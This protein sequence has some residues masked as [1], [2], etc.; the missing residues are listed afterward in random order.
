[1][2]ITRSKLLGSVLALVVAFGGVGFAG[3]TLTMDATS[4]TGSGNVAINGV[5][6]SNY[7]IGAS[8]TTGTITIGGTAQ[9]GVIN[10]GNVSTAPAINLGGSVYINGA[11]VG[12][13]LVSTSATDVISIKSSLSSGTD[14]TSNG[15]SLLAGYFKVANTADMTKRQLQGVLSSITMDNNVFAAYGVQGHVAVASGKKATGS[16]GN[17]NIAGLSGKVSL[18]GTTTAGVV[19]AGLFTIDG[20]GTAPLSNGVWVD[21]GGATSPITSGILLSGNM[22]NNI[23]L[24]SG[25]VIQTGTTAITDNVTSCATLTKGS[26]YINT[27]DG[28][29]YICDGTAWQKITF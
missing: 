19:S 15:D 28:F 26:L 14:G 23:T 1:M 17:G 29:L 18:A 13:A 2:N 12:A 22:T 4:I 6:A 21:A 11:G 25:A 7:T 3:A 9:T 10:I 5:A 20:A 8:T 16:T 24:S 27:T